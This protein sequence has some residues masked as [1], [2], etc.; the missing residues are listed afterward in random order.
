MPGTAPNGEKCDEHAA[1]DGLATGDDPGK[2]ANRDERYSPAW[3]VEAVR[4]LMAGIDMDPA[5]S[6]EANRTVGAAKIYTRETDGLKHPWDKRIFLNPPFSTGLRPWVEKLTAEIEAKRVEQAFV[7]GPMDMLCH[8]AAPW[9][10]VLVAGSLLVPYRRLEF[11]N[12]ETGQQAGPRFGT[13]CAYW[14]PEQ[15]RFVR[16]FGETGV[17]L[18]PA[19]VREVP[20]WQDAALS[21]R[22][23]AYAGACH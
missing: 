22:E 3:L 15:H 1:D 13:F 10:R 16:A 14:G 18:Q 2:L 6:P 12:P 11:L 5:S 7:I 8:L 23:T 19:K 4:D 21:D 9:F 17:I 20:G